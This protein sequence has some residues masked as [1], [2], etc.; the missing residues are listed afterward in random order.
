MNRRPLLRMAGIVLAGSVNL[1][2][3]GGVK[4][5]A[6]NREAVYFTDLSKAQPR[7]ALSI[8]HRKA[9]WQ[10]LAYKTAAREG[11]MLYTDPESEAVPLRLPL[12][13][14]GW[15]ALFVGMPGIDQ[16]SA[17]V[18]LKLS[19]DR[20]FRLFQLNPGA[21]GCVEEGFWKVADLTGQEVII[22]QAGFGRETK[23]G[24]L[25]HVKCVPLTAE[26]VEQWRREESQTESRRLIAFNDGHAIFHSGFTRSPED[27]RMWIEPLKGTDFERL[28]WGALDMDV[29][30]YPAKAATPFGAGIT[31]FFA[32]G[33]RLFAEILEEYQR[34]GRNPLEIA[35]DAAHEA[36]LKISFAA[37]MNYLKP[38]PYDEVFGKFF[39]DHPELWLLQR[40]G[41]PGGLAFACP[42]VSYANEQVRDRMREVIKEIARLNPD[43]IHLLYTRFP[44]FIGYEDAAVVPFR[45]RFGV[46]P[47]DLPDDDPRWLDFK[48]DIMT[49]FMKKL[50]ADLNEVGAAQGRT[51]ELSASVEGRERDLR[52][53]GIDVAAWMRLG[54]LDWVVAYFLEDEASPKAWEAVEADKFVRWA[55]S[56]KCK[57]YAEMQGVAHEI[58]LPS[59]ERDWDKQAAH[60]YKLGCRGLSF[61]D[62]NGDA[63]LLP[64]W[65]K[66]RWL[67]HRRSL[68]SGEAFGFYRDGARD[69]FRG[70]T[71]FR[72]RDESELD[73]AR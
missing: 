7:S 59:P 53:T 38:S 68:L 65:N 40:D 63:A 47:R 18:K 8:G 3:A 67:G 73:R 44:P 45:R 9:K 46:S 35:R 28:V 25:G 43:G 33:D 31:S 19:G 20:D 71:V 27:L 15:H 11:R 16:L 37:R 1:L 36:G 70:M 21:Y 30:Q 51:I 55:A 6:E 72:L 4:S 54:L 29:A 62:N 57:V 50:R 14:K 32:R 49:A 24:I 69:K 2:P 48:A 23:A 34:L 39:W 64:T 41:L 12:N 56:T 58:G 60:F 66:M 13:L 17:Y 22:A 52:R 26:E 42:A 10:V 5:P 61:W